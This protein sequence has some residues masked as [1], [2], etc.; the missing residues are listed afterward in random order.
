MLAGR[1]GLIGVQVLIWSFNLFFPH[2][3]LQCFVFFQGPKMNGAA[4]KVSYSLQ[5]V[6]NTHLCTVCHRH[7]LPPPHPSRSAHP[8]QDPFH[9]VHLKTFSWSSL[10]PGRCRRRSRRMSTLSIGK[11]LAHQ[12]LEIPF[13]FLV[14]VWLLRCSNDDVNDENDDGEISSLINIGQ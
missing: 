1:F 13:D 9:T 10:G 7:T 6:I 12:R 14:I 3:L 8:C 5:C 11:G 2:D 4:K